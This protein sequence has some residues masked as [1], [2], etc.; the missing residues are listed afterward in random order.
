MLRKWRKVG[1]KL[2]CILEA[3]KKRAEDGCGRLDE[4]CVEML[5][6]STQ[7]ICSMPMGG[8]NTDATPA[9]IT[10]IHCAAEYE[11]RNGRGI[12]VAEAAK[13]LEV[14][15]PAVSRTL[16]TI[17]SKGYVERRA[18]DHDRRSVRICVTE[19]GTELL[20]RV[21]RMSV[22]ALDEILSGFTDEEIR[23][24]ISLQSKFAAGIK[25]YTDKRKLMA[26]GETT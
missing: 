17:E 25:E 24:M 2:L 8:A 19:S 22:E 18:D 4:E 9:E 12:A 21:I 23:T 15:V 10:L 20:Y 26:K 13:L 11:K 5:M 14:S 1:E 3:L 7:T 6:R 16:R